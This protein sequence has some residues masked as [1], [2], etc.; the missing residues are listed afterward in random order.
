MLGCN[1]YVRP[2]AWQGSAPAS[3]GIMLVDDLTREGVAQLH[4]DGLRPAVVTETSPRNYQAWVRLSPTPLA[5]TLATQAARELAAR[6]G[7]DPASADWRHYGRLA[8]LTNRKPSRVQPDG[9]YPYVLLHESSG[10]PAARAG[11]LLEAAAERLRRLE[12]Q[13]EA[14][15]ADEV[16]LL[17]RVAGSYDA[18]RGEASLSPAPRGGA[19]IVDLAVEYRRH[20]ERL[21]TRYPHA[22]MSRLDYAVLRDLATRRPDA[23]RQALGQALR[24]GSPNV[25]QRKTNERWLTAYVEHTT[26]AVLLNLAVQR[27]RAAYQR[28]QGAR[29]RGPPTSGA[30]RLRARHTSAVGPGRRACACATPPWGRTS[31]CR[32]HPHADRQESPS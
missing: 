20:A 1:V 16:R 5:P 11:E 6:Y 12:R 27:A 21:I 31:L 2:V 13:A 29:G 19:V 10:Q 32:M 17:A 25:A 15:R 9:R 8:G 14:L 23:T 4:R 3:A 28:E 7:G 18:G 22:D 30:A 26:T 24:L